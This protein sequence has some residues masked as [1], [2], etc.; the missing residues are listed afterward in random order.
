MLCKQHDG[1]II[2]LE[3]DSRDFNSGDK[4]QKKLASV[5]TYFSYSFHFLCVCGLVY[6]EGMYILINT[7]D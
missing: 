3:F 2:N 7:G 6:E 5:L 4:V 1:R